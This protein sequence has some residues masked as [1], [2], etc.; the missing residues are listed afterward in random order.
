MTEQI[1]K[2]KIKS[3]NCQARVTAEEFIIT[4]LL[5]TFV[6]PERMC[7]QRFSV[8]KV[9][10]SPL[11]APLQKISHINRAMC[12]LKTSLIIVLIIIFLKL[13]S[14]GRCWHQLS[15][16]PSLVWIRRPVAREHSIVMKLL[17]HMRHHK[18]RL[19]SGAK[20]CLGRGQRL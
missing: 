19:R 15:P 20:T 12:A 5:L 11:E 13:W 6:R 17:L 9:Q 2:K 8:L 3:W 7:C 4:N 18:C 14:D 16:L 1:S 10:L